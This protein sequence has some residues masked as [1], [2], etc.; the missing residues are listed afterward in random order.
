MQQD[1]NCNND[2][3]NTTADTFNVESNGSEN[4]IFKDLAANITDGIFNL[5]MRANIDR[6][7]YKGAYTLDTTLTLT[8][9][10]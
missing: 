5:I 7:T 8:T 4:T 3:Y 9:T 2:Y 1:T 6:F 10:P